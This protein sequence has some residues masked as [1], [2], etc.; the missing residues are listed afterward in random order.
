VVVLRTATTRHMHASA[1]GVRTGMPRNRFDYLWNNLKF[2]VQPAAAPAAGATGT[3]QFRWFLVNDFVTAINQ[4]RAAHVTPADTLCVDESFS[5]W[6]GQRGDWSS[7]GMHM[8]VAIERKP[9]NGCEIQNVA[10]GRSG[11]MLRL[12][13]VTTAVDQAASL[14]DADRGLLHGTAVLMRL[15][16][17]WAGSERIVCAD[18]HIASVEAAEALRT[19][20]LRFIRVLKTAYRRFPIE[21]LSVREL[22]AR[23]DHVSMAH[24]DETGS[25]DMMAILWLDRRRRCFVATA[26]RTRP[27]KPCDRLRSLETHRASPHYNFVSPSNQNS[28]SL[29]MEVAWAEMPAVEGASV[30]PLL[31]GEGRGLSESESWGAQS[32]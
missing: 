1:F 8:Y 10:C 11:I 4:H 13:I 28:L 21:I 22:G 15:V 32:G 12:K 3:E 14:S 6:Y 23:G 29:N 2:S 31:G 9:E 5:K 24:V 20:G 18:Y 27:G 16:P 7:M 19:S 25:P 30:S 17:P 26:E